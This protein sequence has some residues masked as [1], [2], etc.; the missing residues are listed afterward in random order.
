ME[1][2]KPISETSPVWTGGIADGFESGTGTE[3]D[4]F[5]IAT[6]E[7]LAYLAEAVN[8]GTSF[9]GQFIVLMRS[10]ALNGSAEDGYRMPDAPD[11]EWIPIGNADSPFADSFDGNGCTVFGVYIDS[12]QNCVGLFGS[13]VGA[14]K[15]VTIAELFIC[16][17]YHVGSIVGSNDGMVYGCVGNA[18]V[19]GNRDVG[20]I[21]GLNDPNGKAEAC[22][23]EGTVTSLFYVGNAGG[24]AGFNYGILADCLNTG[25]VCGISELSEA[26]ENDDEGLIGCCSPPGGVGGIVGYNHGGV[27]LRYVS[28]GSVAAETSYVGGIT[29]DSYGGTVENCYYLLGSCAEGSGYGTALSDDDMGSM[30]SFTGFDFDAVR[31]MGDGRPVMG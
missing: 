17:G 4:P 29:G 2:A 26:T 30:Q 22:S 24:I 14:V 25:T 20:G 9:E 31:S 21:V 23:S 10:I 5:V 6:A 18:V 19:R 12:E 28:C 7:Q 15:N 27:V 1:E 3:Q 13:S 11:N 16:G 8:G